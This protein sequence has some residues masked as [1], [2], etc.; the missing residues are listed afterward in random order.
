MAS[1]ALAS[2]ERFEIGRVVERVLNVLRRNPRTLL[3]AALLLAAI[4]RAIGAA[5]QL[6]SFNAGAGPM[7]PGYWISGLIGLASAVVLQPAL[8][9]GVVSDLSG[10]KA[11]LGQMLNVAVRTALPALVVGVIVYIA[12]FIG[13][14]LLIVPGIIVAL[15]L[16]VATPARVIEGPGIMR[17]LSRSSELT[18]GSRWAIL[19]FFVVLFVLSLLFS[20]LVGL[21]VSLLGLE[22]GYGAVFSLF[23]NP[24]ASSEI[25]RTSMSWSHWPT[26]LVVGPLVASFQTLIGAAAIASV[27]YE[28]RWVKDGVRGESLAAAFD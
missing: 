7:G 26:L 6:V 19:G 10:G 17:A 24:R 5:I 15:M 23:T 25:V 27:Y 18:Q 16:C 20:M 2:S 11:T 4:P 1:V 13:L 22:S 9:F 12:S 14:C 28:L 8:L 21:V 3:L